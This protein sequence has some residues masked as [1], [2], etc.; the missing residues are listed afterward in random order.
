VEITAAT[1]RLDITDVSEGKVF[2]GYPAREEFRR[3]RT[4]KSE[5]RFGKSQIPPLFGGIGCITVKNAVSGKNRVKIWVVPS[6]GSK[7]L[8]VDSAGPEV[9]PFFLTLRGAVQRITL[10]TCGR[11]HAFRSKQACSR[12]RVPFTTISNL[13]QRKCFNR[14]SRGSMQ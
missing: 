10:L 11:G 9:W 14:L 4:V 12:E 13:L 5:S 8:R 3:T 1:R 2:W 6:R 7:I